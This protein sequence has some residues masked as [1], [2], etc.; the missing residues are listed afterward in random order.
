MERRAPVPQVASALVLTVIEAR[1]LGCLFEKQRTVADQYPLTLKALVSACNQATSREPVLQLSDHEVE[2][3]IA[4]LKTGGLARLVHPSHGRSATRYRQVADEVWQL[5]PDAT[6]IVAV[7]LL[8]GP[9]TVAELR[10]RTERIHAFASPEEIDEALDALALRG[11]VQQIPRLPGQKEPRWQQLLAHEPSET[12]GTPGPPES[13]TFIEQ[14]WA[15]TTGVSRPTLTHSA[16]RPAVELAARV[17]RAAADELAARVVELEDRVARL[18][19]ALA[20][21]L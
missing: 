6:A 8:R 4:S 18:E 2:T 12:S 16:Q 7:L 15:P 14:G 11:L 19:G 17:D 10:T 13:S 20:D 1:V 5:E 3:A 21:L 9:Q